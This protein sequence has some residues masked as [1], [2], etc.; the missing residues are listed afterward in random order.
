MPSPLVPSPLILV[1]GGANVDVKVAPSQPPTEG[2]STPGEIHVVPGGVARNVAEVLAR[3][4]ARVRLAAVLGDDAWGA[5]LLAETAAAGVDLQFVHRQPG[6]TGIFVSMERRGVADTAITEAAPATAWEAAPVEEADLVFLD[7]NPV[8]G[9]LRALGRR[10]RRLALVGTSP[11]KVARLRPLLPQAW[12]LCLTAAEA[13]TLVGEDADDRRGVDLARA[14]CSLGP[15]RVLMTE[16]ARGFGLL[17]DTWLPVP[18]RPEAVVNPTGA[19]DTAAA[20]VA[21]GLLVG[22]PPERVLGPAARAAAMTVGI[23]GNV[24]PQVGTVMVEGDADDSSKPV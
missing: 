6:R 19:G 1:A 7:A 2:V 13:Q 22:W 3:L 11:A 10:A 24:H 23:W 18:A 21:F 4:G 5:W 15:E 8:E 9:A 17:A 12:L 20:V 14:V 16:G